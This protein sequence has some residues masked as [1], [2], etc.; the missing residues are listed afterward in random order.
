MLRTMTAAALVLSL[1][2]C[3][4]DKEGIFV[5]YMPYPDEMICNGS[6]SENIIDAN[7]PDD[8]PTTVTDW[9]YDYQAQQSDA[10]TFVQIFKSRDKQVIVQINDTVYVGTEDG[11]EIS[12]EWTNSNV[13]TDLTEHGPSGY[14]YVETDN[15]TW[16]HTILLT[17]NKDSKGYDGNWKMST[18]TSRK[19][20]ESDTWDYTQGGANPYQVGEIN[21]W[22]Q[23][24]LEGGASN[25]WDQTDC[26]GDPCFIDL[27]E[28][29]NGSFNFTL[30][31][32]DLDPEA[33]DGVKDAGQPN[34][35]F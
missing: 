20:E 7:A 30:V 1:G 28:N 12:V 6:I 13:S 25:N 17:P 4:Y 11:G 24:D 23:S 10:V 14:R 32:T 34:G 31:E 15:T 8:L 18:T 22:I 33:Y 5:G 29:C 26:D 19:A 27:T 16:K 2:G 35:L 3:T 9:V 21:D